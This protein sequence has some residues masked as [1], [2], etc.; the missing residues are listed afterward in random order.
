MNNDI[1]KNKYLK[2]VIDEIDIKNFGNLK[3]D[4]IKYHQQFANQL[5][6]DDLVVKNY[7][8]KDAIRNLNKE[9]YYQFLIL[10]DNKEVI[11]ILEYTTQKS[12]IDNEKIVYL[13]DLYIVPQC[14]GTGIGEII[15]NSIKELNYRIELECW[16]GM[17]SNNFYKKLGMK[18]IKT[19]YI[20]NNVKN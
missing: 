10:N 3:V 9:N 15:F 6:L 14:R 1:V 18:E 5:G 7:C 8:Y 16:Y 13:K 12:D 4:L 11:G 2:K 19:R 20:F 17:P